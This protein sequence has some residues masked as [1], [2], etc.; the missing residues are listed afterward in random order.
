MTPNIIS[1]TPSMS[2]FED[3]TKSLES[4]HNLRVTELV[5]DVNNV[6]V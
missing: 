6:G 2:V 3:T 1:I 4:R 5:N